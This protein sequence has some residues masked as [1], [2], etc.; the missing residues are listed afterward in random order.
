MRDLPNAGMLPPLSL[1]V[2]PL[3]IGK[4]GARNGFYVGGGMSSYE[5]QGIVEFKYLTQKIKPILTNGK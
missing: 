1:L 2:T 3:H 4:K 5:F